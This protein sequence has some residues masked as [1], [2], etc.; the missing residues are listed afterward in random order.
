M[1]IDQRLL[2]I[3]VLMEGSG[4]KFSQQLVLEFTD[5]IVFK[6][7]LRQFFPC[8]I[9]VFSL[10]NIVIPELVAKGVNLL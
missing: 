4:N 8:C 3:A 5:R 10:G 2:Y 9:K 6:V 7:G 1:N